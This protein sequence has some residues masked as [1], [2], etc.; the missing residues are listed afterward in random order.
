[1]NLRPSPAQIE[2]GNYS[3]DHVSVHGLR[4]SVEN[5]AG[6]TRRGKGAD[7]KP[8]ASKMHNDYGYI[9]GTTGRDKDH[10]DVFLSDSHG[11]CDRPF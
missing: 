1:M 11:Q 2:A 8:W 7:G 6:S 9:R 3:K 4:V 5:P 10:V